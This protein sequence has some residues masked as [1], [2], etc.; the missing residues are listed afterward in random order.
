MQAL[1]V[2]ETEDRHDGSGVGALELALGEELAKPLSVFVPHLLLQSAPLVPPVSHFGGNVFVYVAGVH[3][4]VGT[5][6]PGCQQVVALS[7]SHNRKALK[8]AVF[9]SLRRP[10]RR[11]KTSDLRQH[12]G[13]PP[14][15]LPGGGGQSRGGPTNPP[16]TGGSRAPSAAAIASS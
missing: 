2:V 15:A 9:A 8:M 10:V 16:A 6:Q 1:G 14:P 12:R 7:R 5:G 13:L 4:V 11:D 3:D